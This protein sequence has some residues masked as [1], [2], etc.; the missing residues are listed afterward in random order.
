M[1]K[2]FST[3]FRCGVA[4]ALAVPLALSGCGGGQRPRASA[5]ASAAALSSDQ[6]LALGRQYSQCV[7]Q[8]G[9]PN[10]P[11][12]IVNDGYLALPPGGDQ[13]KRA[14]GDNKAA[15]DACRSIISRV[16]D[17][18]RSGKPTG[19]QDMRALLAFAQCVRQHG[20]PQW[21]DPK[22]DGTFPLHGTSLEAEGKSARVVAAFQACRQYGIDRINGS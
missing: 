5:S 9:V 16:P 2:P 15:Q 19:P 7:R 12:L 11:D 20:V 18:P 22:A 8:H 10:F 6:I 3:V 14:L 17:R 4:L 1:M 21:P 13:A